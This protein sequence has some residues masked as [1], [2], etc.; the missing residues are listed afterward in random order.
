MTWDPDLVASMELINAELPDPRFVDAA[1]LQWLY[2]DNP[3]GLAEDRSVDIDGQRVAHY[4]LIPQ[5]YRNADG[6]VSM[7]FSLNAVA[8]SGHQ[9]GGHFGRLGAE[10]YE[11]VGA[12][13]MGWGIG[14]TNDNSTP[15][16]VKNMGWR[17]ICPL[18]VQVMMPV[19][20]PLRGAVHH[21]ITPE[22]LAS[23]DFDALTGDLDD[24][25]AINWTNCCTPQ[26]LRWRLATPHSLFHLHRSQDLVIISTTTV[27]KG[28]RATV[29]LKMLPR[30]G[31]PLGM[32]AD[33][34]VSAIALHHR[35][36]ISVYA[37]WNAH[38]RLGGISPP[39]RFLPSPLNLVLR[40]MNDDYDQDQLEL[41]TYEFLD[42]DAY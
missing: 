38:V 34:L 33:R 21:H 22:F 41:D 23:D 14:V 35:T 18:P 25:P 4:A 20:P 10:I 5:R 13:G 40:A 42:M 29:I 16:V 8:R 12:K 1:Y 7:A 24:H 28:V 19:L 2:R 39:R 17:F 31:R 32:R 27:E 3:Y 9:R 15:T 26:Y 30:A 37:G 11:A 36:P 6:P